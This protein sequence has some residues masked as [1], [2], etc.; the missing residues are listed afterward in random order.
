MLIAVTNSDETNMI[1]C[2]VAYSLFRTPTKMARVRGDSYL[3]H[4]ELFCQEALPVDVLI[5]PERIVTDYVQR[6]IETPGALQV[7]D[8]ADGRVL[9][10]KILA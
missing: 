10:V 2:Q 7:L 8:F 1:A 3:R 9:T 4:P 5:S 6:L